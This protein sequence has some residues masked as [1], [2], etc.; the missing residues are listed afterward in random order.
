MQEMK[1]NYDDACEQRLDSLK[2]RLS[3]RYPELSNKELDSM[4]RKIFWKIICDRFE[5]DA[6]H[7][8][9]DAENNYYWNWAGNEMSFA[10]S[11][12]L[13]YEQYYSADLERKNEHYKKKGNYKAI[14]TIDDVL[15]SEKTAPEELILSIGK[16]GDTVSSEI[17]KKCFGEYIREMNK[18]NESHGNHI[19]TLNL[20]IHRD[21]EGVDHL[22]LRRVWDYKDEHGN[23]VLNQNKALESA[24]V[25]LPKPD[26]KISRYNNRKITFDAMMREKWLDICEKNGIMIE[27]EPVKNRRHLSTKDYKNEQ[28]QAVLTDFKK[29]T[30]EFLRNTIDDFVIMS[31]QDKKHK[32][33]AD[34]VK[35]NRDFIDKAQGF[36]DL[37]DNKY[38]LPVHTIPED[39]SF[40]KFLDWNNL[41]ESQIQELH[42]RELMKL[43]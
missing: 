39:D 35:A 25:A 12:K 9:P 29:D 26:K 11:E 16:K 31:G 19:K 24:G 28:M 41:S 30:I 10:D 15:K 22:H 13:F 5:I 6:T 4:G 8:N 27:R 36:F 42:H 40:F 38:N 1:E 21:E 17:A 18:W 34:I 14:R 23:Y 3:E 2:E 32:S 20:A 7:I 33:N 43:I 37:L